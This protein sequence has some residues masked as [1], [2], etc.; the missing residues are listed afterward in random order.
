[1]TRSKLEICID[2]L[3]VLVFCGPM[4]PTRIT[5][6]A[7]INYR[8]LKTVLADLKKNNLVEERKLKKTTIVYA[9][10]PKATRILSDF[11]ELCKILA[12]K[13]ES[14]SPLKPALFA[15]HGQATYVE[16]AEWDRI[17]FDRG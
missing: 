4:R 13:D 17:S 2:T 9:A 7:K 3:E 15:K 16:Q 14:V 12:T 5:Y 1:M 10:T 11:R 8:T 6:K